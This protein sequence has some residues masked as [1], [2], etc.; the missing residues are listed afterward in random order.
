MRKETENTETGD[1][2]MRQEIGDRKHETEDVRQET[3]DKRQETEEVRQETEVMRQR[4]GPETGDT[5]M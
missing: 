2:R 3:E 1:M 5:K 4:R